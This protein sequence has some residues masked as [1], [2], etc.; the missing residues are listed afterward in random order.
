[1]SMPPFRPAGQDRPSAQLIDGVAAQL[2]A[3]PPFAQMAPEHLQ[4]LVA[5]ASLRYFAPDEPVLTP[6]MGPVQHLLCI[7]QGGVIGQRGLADAVGDFRYDV[8]DLFPVGAGLARRPVTSHYTAEGDTF[9]LVIPTAHVETIAQA[10]AP[11]ADFLSR[12]MVQLLDLSRQALQ[13]QVASQTLSQQS[14]ETALGDLVRRNPLTVTPQTP[15]RT[16]LGLMARQ[17][18]G[19]VLIAET[20]GGRPA[21]IVTRHDVL[22]RITLPQVPL[23]T[24]VAEVMSTPIHTLQTTQTVQDAALLMS[25]HGIR[26]VP[27]MDGTRLVSIVSER[28]LFALQ[29]LSLKQVGNELRHAADPDTL[30]A[31]APQIRALARS[32]VGQGVQARQLT[33]LI[34]YLND[35]LAQRAVYLLCEAHGLDLGQAC[36]LAF[37]SEGRSEQTIAT[38]QDNGLILRDHVTPAERERWLAMALAVNRLLDDCGYPLCKGQVMASNP[39]CWVHRKI[40]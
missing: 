9:C 19:S 8:G 16:A 25:M 6:S 2:R 7:T 18:V 4:R 34:S 31:A 13:A 23:D 21:G 39:D 10:S 28:D 27:I 30:R 36:W 11:L 1:M 12:R 29:R 14:F 32:L 20:D 38:D 5:H 40:C 22:G 33:A 15:L 3:H 26:H 17:R 24:A 37:G 35:L